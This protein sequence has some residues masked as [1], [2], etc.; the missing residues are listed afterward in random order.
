MLQCFILKFSPKFFTVFPHRFIDQVSR[1]SGFYLPLPG[2]DYEFSSTCLHLNYK[3]T[4]DAKSLSRQV[5]HKHQLTQWHTELNTRTPLLYTR[6]HAWMLVFSWYYMEAAYVA[7][8]RSQMMLMNKLDVDFITYAGN[9][10]EFW[11]D[12]KLNFLENRNV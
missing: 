12:E 4:K 7:T 5:A 3:C 8:M 10:W 1:Y 2:N 6:S 11:G 9:L